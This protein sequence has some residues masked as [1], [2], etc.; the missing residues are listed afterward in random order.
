MFDTPLFADPS[1][2]L[3]GAATGFVFGFLLQKGGATRFDVIVG[4]FLLRDF[5]ML[6]IMMT[7]IVVGAV[8][9]WAMYDIGWIAT[10]HVKSTHLLA[11]ALGGGLFG[12]GM[13]VLGYCPGTGIAAIGDGSR[14][15]V[16]GAL[17]MLVGAALYAE[18]HPWVAAHILP[19]GALG[20]VTAASETAGSPWGFVLAVALLAAVVFASIEKRE[21][22]SPPIAPGV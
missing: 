7:A 13:V 14:H 9:I 17:G 6:K 5:T 19:V 22:A 12:I 4:Q 21:H 2:L 16:P 20:K 11:N 1:V 18:V 8:G 15:A 10:L 3:M